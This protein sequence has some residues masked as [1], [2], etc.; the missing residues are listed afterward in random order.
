M[1]KTKVVTGKTGLKGSVVHKKSSGDET[2]VKV[3][4]KKL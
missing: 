3:T 1:A 4:G 2:K